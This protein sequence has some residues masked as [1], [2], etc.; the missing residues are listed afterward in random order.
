MARR[1][2]NMG[3]TLGRA[4]ASELVEKV[5]HNVIALEQLSAR[6]DKELDA[7]RDKYRERIE[8]LE[9]EIRQDSAV[10][11]SWARANPAEFPAGKRC[12]E[13][14]HGTLGFRLG[15]WAVKFARGLK[16]GDVVAKLTAT[17]WGSAYAPAVPQLDKDAILRDREELAA[18]LHDVGIELR[19]EDRF[20]IEPRQDAAA[21]VVR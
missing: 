11:E 19:Q 10:L 6:Q 8:A 20:Y 18:K 2:V 5:A 4:D 3:A 14:P 13:F 12:I 17:R 15:N 1:V 9:A 21:A 7:V 16:V